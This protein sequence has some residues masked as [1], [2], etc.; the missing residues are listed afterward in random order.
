[1]RPS[2]RSTYSRGRGASAAAWVLASLL[3]SLRF[4]GSSRVV[5]VALG[6]AIAAS[7]IGLMSLSRRQAKLTMLNG[8]LVFSGI[9]GSRMLLTENSRG[10]VVNV[11]VAWG[12]ASGRRSQLWLLM[13]EKG[14]TAIGLNRAI[15][16][17]EQLENVREHL[18]LPLAVDDTARRPAELRRM[19]PGS[20]PWWA[21]HP[22]VATSLMIVV[23]AVLVLVS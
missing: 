3:Y 10:Q 22:A 8:A 7:V 12:K 18:G 13:N 19:Y 23:V 17:Y 15:W 11:E 6:V 14:R 4:H 1:V 9:F 2:Q 16:G 20:V 5:V 21:A